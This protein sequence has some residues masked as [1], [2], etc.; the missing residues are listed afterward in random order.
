LFWKYLGIFVALITVC[1]IATS[2]MQ[3]RPWYDETQ[4]SLNRLQKERAGAAAIKINAFI[5]TIQDQVCWSM[6]PGRTGGDANIDQRREDYYRMLRQTPSITEVRYLDTTGIE[7]LKVSRVGISSAGNGQD[8]SAQDEFAEARRRGNADCLNVAKSSYFGPVYFKNGSEPYMKVS[9]SEPGPPF[10]V[11]VADVN[12]KLIWNIIQELKVGETG[13]AYVV[14]SDGRL[15]AH[16]D[17]SLVLKNT[18]FSNL[19]QVKNAIPNADTNGNEDEAAEVGVDHLNRQVLASFAQ[20]D[21]PGW[22]VFVELPLDEAFAPINSSVSRIPYI[23]LVGIMLSALLSLFLARRMANPIRA[24]QV[25][26]AQIGSGALDQRISIK[27]GDE[28]ESLADE[29]NRMAANLQESY[30]GLEERVKERTQELALAMQEIQE[31]SVQL[32]VVSQHKSDF[33]AHMSHELRTPLNAVIGFSHVLLQ[34]MYGDLT[35]KQEDYMQDILTSGKH[36]LDLINDILD[37][38]KIEAGRMDLTP[39]F[40]SL[41]GVLKE[42]ITVIRDQAAARGI[43]VDLSIAEGFD[44]VEADHRKIKQI[45]FNLLSNA[46]KFTPDGGRISVSAGIDTEEVLVTVRDTGIGIPPDEQQRIFEDFH[47]VAGNATAVGTG[48]GLALTRKFVELHGGRVWVESEV[49][50]GSAFTFSLPLKT[51]FA[52]EEVPFVQPS[53][54][55]STTP[56]LV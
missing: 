41:P 21:P 29:F 15:I 7:R 37:L 17:L 50:I 53:A 19:P 51:E 1:S 18:D 31:K 35:E 45:I 22:F 24:L 32:E 14:A 26:A 34:R 30:A 48:L 20:V 6:A 39:S 2:L 55:V 12:L 36:L 47:Q 56:T 3:V 46:I 11:T 9:I 33:L 10:G 54:S 4:N 8:F 44:L 40:F 16:R 28:L 38:S 43:T 5:K 52:V 13:L 27:T 25:S 42:G 23:L 49:G